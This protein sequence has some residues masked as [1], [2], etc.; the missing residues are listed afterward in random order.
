MKNVWQRTDTKIEI[1]KSL[2]PCGW[3]AWVCLVLQGSV[4]VCGV[5][6]WF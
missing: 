2:W 1:S 5:I 3:E 4:F 6:N